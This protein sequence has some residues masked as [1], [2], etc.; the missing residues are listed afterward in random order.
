[1]LTL[2]YETVCGEYPKS[3]RT[4]SNAI[5][6]DLVTRWR[7]ANELA[8]AYSRLAETICLMCMIINGRNTQDRSA[9]VWSFVLEREWK[10][11]LPWMLEQAF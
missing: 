9:Y 3:I 6:A 5:I 4:N 1:M 10:F 2:P 11:Y 7:Q 8:L